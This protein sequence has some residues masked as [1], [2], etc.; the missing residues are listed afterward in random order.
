MAN[1]MPRCELCVFSRKLNKEDPRECRRNSPLIVPEG[2]DGQT[3]YWSGVWPVVN[4]DAWCGRYRKS[5]PPHQSEIIYRMVPCKT[6]HGA[7]DMIPRRKKITD[8]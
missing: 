8:D 2:D 7:F 1:L 5:L 4:D 3:L 6:V